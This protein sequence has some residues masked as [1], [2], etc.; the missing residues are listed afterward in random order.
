LLA[1]AVQ[2][3]HAALEVYTKVEMT[4]DWVR[5]QN[6][7]GIAL[8]TGRHPSSLSREGH[9]YGAASTTLIRHPKTN[10]DSAT[11]PKPRNRER[12]EQVSSPH[13]RLKLTQS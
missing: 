1:A 6:N 11:V 13:L 8:A 3:Y 2:G 12:R 7:L 9:V 5:T 10:G 4:Q